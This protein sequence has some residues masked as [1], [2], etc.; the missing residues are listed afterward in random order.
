MVLSE[1]HLDILRLAHGWL[2]EGAVELGDGGASRE[3]LVVERS[4]LLVHAHRGHVFHIVDHV[5]VKHSHLL[6]L[7]LLFGALLGLLGLLAGLVD[8]A[9]VGTL[10]QVDVGHDFLVGVC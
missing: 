6:V 1:V 8:H 4:I 3:D 5:L 9:F 2:T 7:L 10:G